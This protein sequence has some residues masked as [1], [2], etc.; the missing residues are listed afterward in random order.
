YSTR[1]PTRGRSF[2]RQ[3][4]CQRLREQ[5][6]PPSTPLLG[7][8]TAPAPGGFGADRDVARGYQFLGRRCS[9]AITRSPKACFSCSTCS[10]IDRE[11]AVPPGV[12]PDSSSS[13]PAA[14]STSWTWRPSI[15]VRQS[16]RPTVG[17][18]HW[19]L[20]LRLASTRVLP[21]W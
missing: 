12:Y 14:T 7:T 5:V 18:S 17:G 20:E 21:S 9:L 19:S 13:V 4:G 6:L 15:W 8:S 16:R 10:R 11:V 2:S 3:Q 1:P